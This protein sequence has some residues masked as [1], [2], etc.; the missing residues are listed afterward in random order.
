MNKCCWAKTGSEIAVE[1]SRHLA[2][3]FKPQAS[4]SKDSNIIV[5]TDESSYEQCSSKISPIRKS[6]V[7][8]EIQPKTLKSAVL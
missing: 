1:F 8:K 6:E 4:I 3:L 2:E 5:E 7:L